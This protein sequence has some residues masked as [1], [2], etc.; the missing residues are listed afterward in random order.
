MSERHPL[1]GNKDSRKFK[2]YR[3]EFPAI[4]RFDGKIFSEGF[5]IDHDEIK[6]Q[7][8]TPEW[9]EEQLKASS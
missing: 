6:F 2:I 8:V 7:E 5:D 9:A 4:F 1:L 3:E